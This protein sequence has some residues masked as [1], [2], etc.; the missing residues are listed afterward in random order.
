MGGGRPGRERHL[1]TLS[2]ASLKMP[3]LHEERKRAALCSEKEDT[4][5][6]E[7]LSF[8]KKSKKITNKSL[9]PPRP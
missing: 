1:A 6:A 8:L 9:R 5:G 7:E 3:R 4:V 2:S